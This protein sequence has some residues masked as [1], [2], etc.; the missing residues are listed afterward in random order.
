M[1]AS[2]MIGFL[3]LACNLANMLT[4][5]EKAGTP[6]PEVTVLITQETVQ[7]SPTLDVT[8][9]ATQELVTP[10]P[11]VDDSQPA[12][13]LDLCSLVTNAEV[14]AILGEPASAPNPV[15]GGCSFTNVKD[16]LYAVS[17]GA[18]QGVDTIG[19]M[20]G[21]AMLLGFAGAPLDET[22]MGK[23]KML[24]DV[25]DYKGFFAELVA[26]A[27]GS[28]IIQARLIESGGNDLV[29][30]AW[31]TAQSRRQGAFVAVR[32][33]T[34]VNINLVVTDTRT[35]ENMLA[36]STGLVEEIYK[37][38]P[39]KFSLGGPAATATSVPT[40]QQDLNATPTL[41]K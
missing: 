21:Q 14:E 26:A 3:L 24:A 8:A 7:P 33:S 10:S 19:I 37:R 25:M 38:L 11:T 30:W 6:P 40:Q 20:Q 12:T 22:R 5:N 16:G 34:L 18:A 31:I 39:S 17:V 35:E 9:T 13:N 2:G 1:L 28:S 4:S 29:Y 41:V 23:L 27:K 15:N 32:G 36:A